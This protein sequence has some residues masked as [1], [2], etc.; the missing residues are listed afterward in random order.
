MAK[1]T[2]VVSGRVDMLDA[3]RA[4]VYINRAGTTP[5]EII[6]NVWHHIAETGELPEPLESAERT[7]E[8][9]EALERLRKLRESYSAV[10]WLA[11]MTDDDMKEILTQHIIEKYEALG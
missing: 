7:K 1:G 4:Q 8:A 3:R 11:T 10:P 2:T 9:A 5:N 6:R